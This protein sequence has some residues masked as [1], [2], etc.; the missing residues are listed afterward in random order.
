MLR[1]LSL[2]G[3]LI[4]LQPSVAPPVS[5]PGSPLSD[6]EYQ[7]FFSKLR[8]SWKARAACRLRR[9]Y[10]CSSPE[11]LQLDKEENHGY[12]PEGPICSDFPEQLWFMNFCQFAQYRCSSHKFYLKRILCSRLSPPK[13]DLVQPERSYGVDSWA[14][15]RSSLAIPG[16]AS[17]LDIDRFLQANVDALL[18]YSFA[19]S[20]LEP[21]RK[22]HPSAM[23]R[24]QEAPRVMELPVPPRSQ[25]VPDAPANLPARLKG[26]NQAYMTWQQRLQQ[27]IQRLLDVIRSLETPPSTGP[28]ASG[29]K[30]DQGSTSSHAE[31]SAQEMAASGSLLA[32]DKNEAVTIL[33]RAI[34]DE[35]CISSVVTQA[36]K[37]M[38]EKDLGFGELVCDSL[39]RHHMALCPGCAFCS[40]KREQCQNTTNLRRVNCKTGNFVSYIN[41]QIAAEH[42]A[43][44]SQV[45]S[46]AAW[47]YN[48]M[49]AYS[50]SSEEYWCGH[51][52]MHGCDDPRVALWLQAEYTSFQAGDAPGQ[53]CDSGGVQYPNYCAFKSHQCL[54]HSLQNRRV[55]RVACSQ[56]K[57]YQMLS[58]EEGKEE[59]LLWHRW[60]LS[61]MRD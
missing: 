5:L 30:E 61:L 21:V 46:P 44:G 13:N 3:L 16:Q 45:R 34:Q 2:L 19:L 12:I 58:E 23:A 27:N 15:D 32:L 17:R 28:P 31:K 53:V 37:Q 1:L 52:G 39:G 41:P 29:T 35:N 56:N 49:T 51:L 20:G 42:Q 18:Q 24:A 10:G 9:D 7:I 50:K 40:L 60:F 25:P 47:E 48:G 4:W 43:A 22:Q 54:Q 55:S 33:C 36:W 11:V 57:T 59:V 6:G 38:E 26:R 8:P 14:N